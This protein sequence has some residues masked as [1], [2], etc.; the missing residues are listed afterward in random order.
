MIPVLV[1]KETR[2][3]PVSSKLDL[4]QI[5]TGEVAGSAKGIIV[6]APHPWQELQIVGTRAPN[7]ALKAVEAG[8]YMFSRG[9]ARHS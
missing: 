7:V 3:L 4:S 2:R 5:F 9:T 1:D 6:F 8:L